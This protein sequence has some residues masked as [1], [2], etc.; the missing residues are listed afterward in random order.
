MNFACINVLLVLALAV[1]RISTS[2]S[3][4]SS[5]TDMTNTLARFRCQPWGRETSGWSMPWLA[6]HSSSHS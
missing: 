3:G 6:S 1:Q 4:P 5:G 2:R